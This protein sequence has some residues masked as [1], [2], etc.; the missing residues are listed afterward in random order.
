MSC[1]SVSPVS[2]LGRM[3]LSSLRFHLPRVGVLA[4][5]PT[6]GRNWGKDPS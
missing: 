4:P 2:G 5:F 6:G 1:P 3:D